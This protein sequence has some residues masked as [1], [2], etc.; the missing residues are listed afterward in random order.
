MLMTAG[1][2]TAK[3]RDGSGVV[4]KVTTGCRT[5]DAAKAVLLDLETRADKVRSGK[6]TAA[7]DAVLNHR[8]TPIE[9]HVDAYIA[10]LRG[11]RGKG[12]RVAVSKRHVLNVKH[13]LDCVIGG[14]GFEHLR[15]LN[16][17]AVDG[18]VTGQQQKEAVPAARTHNAH[19]AAVTAFGN[20][21]VQ[22]RRLIVNPFDRLIKLDEKADRRRERRAL[23]EEELH[24]L[25]RVAIVRPL[26]EYGRE[27]EKLPPEK[28]S[29]RR[30]STSTGPRPKHAKCSPISRT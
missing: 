13:S 29:G 22:T 3:Y 24:R 15:D 30:T 1:T 5:L 20:W 2:Y 16:R 7:E 19:L 11:K 21:C 18:W 4:Q 25:L 23:T 26:A 10:H 27:S 9:Q 17:E 14:C 28:Q 6:W 8:A 12:A